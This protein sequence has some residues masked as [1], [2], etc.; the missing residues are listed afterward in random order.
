MLELLIIII[1]KY[2]YLFNYSLIINKDN[3][4]KL[5]LFLFNLS[6]IMQRKVIF[7]FNHVNL[8]LIL[9]NYIS[10]N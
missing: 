8:R 6:L 5:H 9:V 3:Y 1:R 7:K 2:V 4:I 10:I